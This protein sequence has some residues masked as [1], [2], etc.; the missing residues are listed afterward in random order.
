MA[1]VLEEEG[2]GGLNLIIS[3]SPQINRNGSEFVFIFN[4]ILLTYFS[5][6]LSKEKV[7]CAVTFKNMNQTKRKQ[8]KNEGYCFILFVYFPFFFLFLFFGRFKKTKQYWNR[9]KRV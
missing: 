7:S 1:Y 4:N 6:V 5:S 8:E 3:N 9:M 2:G